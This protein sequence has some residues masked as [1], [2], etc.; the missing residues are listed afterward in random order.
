MGDANNQL[1][2]MAEENW[3]LA[4]KIAAANESNETKE[5]ILTGEE[6]GAKLGRNSNV[7]A[8]HRYLCPL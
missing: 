5:A 2:S 1:T 4:D 3:D 7:L 6:H 8:P